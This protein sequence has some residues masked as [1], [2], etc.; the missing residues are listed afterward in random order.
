ML[1]TPANPG[2]PLWVTRGGVAEFERQNPDLA[3]IG[4]IMIEMGLWRRTDDP[5]MHC[6]PVTES[7]PAR[8]CA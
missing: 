6:L 8:G 4:D 5:Q 2:A 1:R 3:G 7:Q